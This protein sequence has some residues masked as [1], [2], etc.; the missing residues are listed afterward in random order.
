MCFGGSSNVKA[1]VPVPPPVPPAPAAP[2]PP[3]SPA[4]PPKPLTAAKE[5][6]GVRPASSSRDRL[7]IQ[8]GT[9]QLRIPLNTGGSSNGGVNL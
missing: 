8:R 6:Q 9:R 1:A 4:P 7:A 5:E 3:E 2:P